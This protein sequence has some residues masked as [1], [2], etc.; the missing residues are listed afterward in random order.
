MSPPSIQ[1][2]IHYAQIQRQREADA[3]QDGPAPTLKPAEH[4]LEVAASEAGKEKELNPPSYSNPVTRVPSLRGWEGDIPDDASQR[5]LRASSWVSA[6]LNLAD[7]FAAC[8]CPSSL[9]GGP[10]RIPTY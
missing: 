8:R 2:L 7:P 4:P 9:Y 6:D 3:Y 1:A 10:P 5:A